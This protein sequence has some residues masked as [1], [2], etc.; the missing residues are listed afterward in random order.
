M[1]IINYKKI[2]MFKCVNIC[3]T[4]YSRLDNFRSV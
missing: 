3:N 4:Y 1:L 2:N